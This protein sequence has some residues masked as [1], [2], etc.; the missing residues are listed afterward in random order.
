MNLYVKCL[1]FTNNSSQTWKKKN[2][3]TNLHSHCIDYGFKW[4]E[5][6]NKE[7]VSDLSINH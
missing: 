4:T 6:I 1:K 5:I 3:K 2:R 7:E